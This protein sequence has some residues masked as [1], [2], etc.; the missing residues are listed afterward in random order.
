M[1]ALIFFGSVVEAEMGTK[2]L[3]YVFFL[4][5]IVGDFAVLVGVIFGIIPAGIP[6]IGA[7]AA[8]FGLLGLAMMKKPFHLVFYPYL[9]PV[10]LLLVAVLYSLYNVLEF[11][12]TLALGIETQIAYIAHLGG[13]AVGAAIGFREEGTKKGFLVLLGIVLILIAIPFVWSYL[14]LLE[15]A[16]Y[17]DIIGAIFR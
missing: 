13:L 11:L 6:T 8:I 10:P 14:Q 3:L 2:K 7:S 9:I 17:T 4:A 16:N 5:G 12:A 1:L 15:I